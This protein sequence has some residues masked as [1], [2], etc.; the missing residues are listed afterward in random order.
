MF[1]TLHKFCGF[2]DIPEHVNKLD[3]KT[4]MAELIDSEMDRKQYLAIE[5]ELAIN[6]A[7]KHQERACLELT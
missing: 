2:I 4:K 7:T 5:L 1:Q 3:C 6:A